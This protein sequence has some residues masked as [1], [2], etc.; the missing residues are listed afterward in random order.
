MPVASMYFSWRP[1]GTIDHIKWVSY[2][3]RGLHVLKSSGLT[4]FV[5]FWEAHVLYI[6]VILWKSTFLEMCLLQT[7][8]RL[9]VL[10]ELS[11]FPLFWVV[12]SELWMLLQ[13]SRRILQSSTCWF[14]YVM[15]MLL[16]MWISVL[17]WLHKHLTFAVVFLYLSFFLFYFFIF[18]KC[19]DLQS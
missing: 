13:Q 6:F 15:S 14:K 11:W 1:L 17:L 12:L 19:P 18:L 8:S 3:C 2:P 5:S 7:R 9:H 10:P 4:S 16:V